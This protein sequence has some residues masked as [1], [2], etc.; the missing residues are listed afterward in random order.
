MCSGILTFSTPAC[1]CRCCDLDKFRSGM[2]VFKLCL[3]KMLALI[4]FPYAQF[5]LRFLRVQKY[6]SLFCRLYFPSFSTS[7][8]GHSPHSMVSSLVVFAGRGLQRVEMPLFLWSMPHWMITGPTHAQSETL[9]MS[10]DRQC[11][12]L[13]SLSHQRVSL[14]THMHLHVG[15]SYHF[16]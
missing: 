3:W 10:M 8:H 1:K 5:W 4:S 15:S 11:H 16:I 9:L 13:Y 7:P 2:Y 12:T 6:F 14:E